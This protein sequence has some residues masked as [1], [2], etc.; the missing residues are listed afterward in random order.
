MS[1]PE[2]IPPS[3][4]NFKHL[5]GLMLYGISGD[6]PDS[7]GSL[8]LLQMLDL[9]SGQRPTALPP[10]VSKLTSL[11][12]LTIRTDEE[13]MAPVQH[14]TWLTELE[15]TIYGNNDA[16]GLD[17]PDLIW[18]L[19]SLKALDLTGIAERLPDAVGNLKNLESLMLR[20]YEGLII[21]EPIGNLSCLGYLFV[22]CEQLWTL[23]ES[24]GNLAVLQR[25]SLVCCHSIPALPES[26]GNLKNLKFIDLMNCNALT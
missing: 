11:R 21:S 22:G 10:S 2:E 14:V 24:I 16:L 18:T 5:T 9:S 1:F 7:I 8:S 12:N 13:G 25:L 3:I 23:P 4:A 15:L 6:I 19:T 20:S 17:Y 26:I